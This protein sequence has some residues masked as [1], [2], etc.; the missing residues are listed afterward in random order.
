MNLD[1]HE[2]V[3]L[4][5]GA[6]SGI[7]RASALAFARAGAKVVVADLTESG[8]SETV[9]LIT[10]AGGEALF[11]QTDVS[12][13]SEVKSLIEK[14]VAR[15]GKLD[16]AHNNAGTE[17]M[18]ASTHDCSEENWDT[19]INTNLK[20]VWLCLKYEITQMLQQRCGAI[21][22]TSS[23][24]GLV[25]FK[26][27]PAYSASKHGVVGLTKTAALEYAKSGV[28]INAVCPG[29]IRTPMIERQVK[30]DPQIEARLL[31][32]QPSGRMGTPEEVAETVL[33]LCSDGASFVTG[34]A[35]QV[36]GGLVAQ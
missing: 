18:I 23:I 16:F 27:C 2:R 3:A 25:G 33:W 7:G 30:G 31:A 34:A 9:A 28:R 1:F 24:A 4:V 32:F 11:V 5:T 22:N 36:D 15:F 6:S 14:I 8:G 26:G 35:L 17:G 21:V 10:S 13:N 19:I 20:G 12:K 29:L